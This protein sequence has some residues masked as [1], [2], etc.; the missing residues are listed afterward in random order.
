[1]SLLTKETDPRFW[2]AI[3]RGIQQK[4][5][6]IVKELCAQWG[7]DELNVLRQIQFVVKTFNTPQGISATVRAELRPEVAAAQQKLQ[8]ESNAD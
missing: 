1:M 2:A 8:E 7:M 6:L 3:F 5:D 4:K